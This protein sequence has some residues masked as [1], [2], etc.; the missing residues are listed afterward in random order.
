MLYLLPGVRFPLAL[1]I[2]ALALHLAASESEG[3]LVSPHV[4]L[5]PVMLFDHPMKLLYH[6]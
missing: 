4:P 1:S 5:V 3:S 2:Q 6:L